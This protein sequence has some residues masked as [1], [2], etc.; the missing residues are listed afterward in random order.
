MSKEKKVHPTEKTR[1]HARN[2]HRE[3]YNFEE[4]IACLPELKNYVSQNIY[5]DDSIDFFNP[6][7]VKTLN[8][9][10]LKKHYNIAHWNIPEHYLCPPIPGRA[11]YIHN[12]ADLLCGNNYGKIPTGK[13]VNC[14]DIGVGANCIYPIIGS[15]EYDWCFVGTDVDAIAIKSANEIVEQNKHLKNNIEIRLQERKNRF[16]KGIIKDE[17]YFDVSI[18]NPPFHSSAQEAQESSIRKVSNLT[19]KK[20]TTPVLNFGGQQN[21]LWCEGGEPRFLTDMIHEST[22]FATSCFW[23]TSLVSKQSNV[24]RATALT[25]QVGATDVKIIPMGQGN[26]TSRILAWTFLTKEE[27]KLWTHA[28]W[29][30]KD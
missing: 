22:K 30:N 13:K 14:L 12:I 1:L 3:R 10:L 21:E 26:K 15:T 20:V 18:C 11:D 7:A 6:M 9:A 28:K 2:K 4:L 19:N 24:T 8:Q 25:H 16:F 27:Q 29:Q 23:F 5:G 17:E